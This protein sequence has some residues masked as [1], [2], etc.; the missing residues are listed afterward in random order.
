[1]AHRAAQ[2]RPVLTS[3]PTATTVR[4]DYLQNCSTELNQRHD[5]YES[6][7]SRTSSTSRR[8][9]TRTAVP[10]DGPTGLIADAEINGRLTMRD[11]ILARRGAGVDTKNPQS[12]NFAPTCW[13]RMSRRAEVTVKRGWTAIDAKVRGSKLVP[14]RQHP[15]GGVRRRSIRQAQA[16]ELVA[17]T[18]AGDERTA[19]RPARRPQLRRRHRRRR[20]PPGLRDAAGGRDGRAQHRRS[21]QLLPQLEPAGGRRRRQRRRLR[22]PGRPHHDPRSRRGDAG[23]LLG[24]RDPAGQRVLEL[25]PRRASS[26]PCGSTASEPLGATA[27][28]G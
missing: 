5:R 24:D 3:G 9:P 14:L 8:R 15:P 18:R 10:D 23:G 22:P 7:S 27:R 19:G 21:A 20:R 12:A 25:R 4:Y 6:S 13:C 11:V 26:A 1:M 16:A 17:P 28:G 2:P